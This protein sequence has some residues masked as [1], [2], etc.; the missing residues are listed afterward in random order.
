VKPFTFPR[1]V[2]ALSLPRTRRGRRRPL[3]E[4]SICRLEVLETRHMLTPTAVDDSYQMSANTTLSVDAASGV[5]A[6]DSNPD[7][8]SMNSNVVSNPSHGTL[9]LNSDGSFS[10]TPTT[11]FSGNDTFAY[12]DSDFVGTSNTATVTITI[13]GAGTPI[14]VNDSYT[15]L[16]DRANSISAA[17]GVLANDTDPNNLTLSASVVTVP[18]HGTLSLNSDGSLVYTPVAGYTGSDNF[19]YQDSD[20]TYTSNVATVS[21]SVTDPNAPMAMMDDYS[22][23]HDRTT[24]VSAANGVLAND[25][26][27]DG[28]SLSAVLVSGPSDGSLTLNSDGSFSYTP[29][30]HYTGNDSFTYESFDGVLY[31]AATTA[32][33]SVTNSAPTPWDDSYDLPNAQTFNV[34]APGVLGNDTDPDGDALTASLVTAP[35]H[36]TL[37]LN[38]DGSFSYTPNAGWVGQDQF[39]YAASDGLASSNATV[40]LTTQYS[41]LSVQDLT[42]PA[43]DTVQTALQILGSSSGTAATAQNLSVGYDSVAGQGDAVIEVAAGLSNPSNPP[44][45]TITASLTFNG[46]AQPD[47]YFTM[48]TLAQSDATVHLAEQV[49]TSGF[50]TG[51]YPFSMTITSP[52]MA[53]PATVDGFVNVVNDSSSPIGKGWTI[54]GLLQLYPNNVNGV[55]AGV[56]LSTGGGQGWYFTQGSGNSYTSPDGLFA[57][58][59]LTAVTG[60]GWQLVS[61]YG[62]TLNFNSSG[63]LTSRVE[64]TTE[65][66]TYNYSGALLT[67]ITD[68]FGRSVNLAYSGGLLSSI[69]DYAG[70]VT[71]FAHSGSLLT[72]ITQP[73]PGGGAPVWTYGYTGNYLTSVIDPTGAETDF[74]Y[75]PSNRLS[76]TT[77]PGG[78][79][80]GASAEQNY[81]YG[82]TDPAYPADLTL[83][84]AVAPDMVDALGNSTG[85]QTDLLGNPTSITDAYGNVTTMQRDAN[86]LVTQLTQPSPDGVQAAPVTTYSYDSLGNETSAT[87]ALSTFGMFTFNSFSE[88]LTFVDL[89]NHTTTWVYDAHGNLLSKQ[90]ALGNTTTW[91]YDQYGRPLTMTLPDPDGAGPLTAP[92]YHY[93]YDSY[94]RLI[95]IT[96]PDNTTGHFSY[97]ADDRP[98]SVEDE[99]SHTT[100]TAYDALG[101]VTSVTNA[102]GGVVSYSYDLDGRVLTTQDEMG[103]VTTNVY[104]SRGELTS[105]TLPDPDGAGPLTSPVWSFT[106]DANADK[107]TQ[108]DPLGRVTSWAYDEMGRVSTVSL[109]D[110]DG[111]G[112]LTSPVTTYGYDNLGR[113]ISVTDAS[114][115]LTQLAY[116]SHNWLTSVTA[117]D[118]DGSGPLTS[119]VTTFG[120]DA[121]GRQT[122]IT[123]PMGHTTTT[124]FDADGRK[125]SVTDNLNHSTTFSYDH[126]SNLLGKRSRVLN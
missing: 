100:T 24:T 116:N 97:D 64:R 74:A 117:P 124:A 11:N 76:T 71:S 58:S 63:Y 19:S 36:G 26:D 22:V 29:I 62:T 48:S 34:A 13:N 59:T 114:G 55:P 82:S 86:G 89:L 37:T 21:L 77:L 95:T 54:P 56:L 113:K 80:I 12:D 45:E 44:S 1:R 120:Y 41:I 20:G 42:K 8:I 33:I 53:A 23:V 65:T 88:P 17:S 109:P 51:R 123:D 104:N 60:G 15:V 70:N 67:S 99:N 39:V 110:P 10:Y 115:G 35:S 87:G 84:S 92:E 105:T 4:L 9:T 27:L 90:D 43:A 78:A 49:D 79:T 32:S 68:E 83:Q 2:T 6:N 28:D 57:F 72:T 69:T 75:D 7:M 121:L 119:P 91:T 50:A 73:D 47:V 85:Y 93:A 111:A 61:Q 101:R 102:A 30:F 18:T 108:T 122:S 125:T 66:T 96:N 81:G 112:P 31:S 25:S 38:S 5:Q 40:T 52:D 98:L 126:D 46:V 16:H 106:Y 14:A 118:P 107:L 94:E 3:A 103:N